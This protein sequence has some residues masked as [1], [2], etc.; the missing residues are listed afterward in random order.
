METKEEYLERMMAQKKP[1]CPHCRTEMTIWEVPPMTFSDGLGWGVPYLY[2]CYNNQCEVFTEGWENIA[3]NYGH[4]SSYRCIRYPFEDNFELMTVF[5]AEGGTQGLVTEET[6]NEQERLKE[7]MKTGFSI[8][9][10]CYVNKDILKIV[11]ML[12]DYKEPLRVRFK[13]AEMLGDI[14]DTHEVVE[15]M[16]N[17]SPDNEKMREAINTAIDK[18]HIR[19]FTRECPSCKEIIKRRAVVCKHC[20]RDVDPLN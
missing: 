6:L 16:R 11:S 14:C 2:V 12:S 20:G 9:A 5:G 19:C 13:A 1:L 15:P 3:E 17:I 8:L 7:A 10:D 18:I 4:R